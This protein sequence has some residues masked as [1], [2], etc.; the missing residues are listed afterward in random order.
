M[1]WNFQRFYS[2]TAVRVSRHHKAI[3]C[4]NVKVFL[5]KFKAVPVSPPYRV[6][7]IYTRCNSS[8][9]YGYF[10]ASKSHVPPI[11][12]TSMLFGMKSTIGFFVFDSSSVEFASVS[13]QT[14]LVNATTCSWNPKQIPKMRD[15]VCPCKVGPHP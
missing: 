2:S 14:C 12:W 1:V 5:V 11:L 15:I 10:V 7:A 8:W 4:N 3:L 9:S 6:R 13:L